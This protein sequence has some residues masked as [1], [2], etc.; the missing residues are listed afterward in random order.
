MTKTVGKP[1]RGQFFEP[2]A[3]GVCRFLPDPDA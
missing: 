3:A 2:A 1:D